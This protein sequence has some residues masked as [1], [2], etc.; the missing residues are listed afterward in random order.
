MSHSQSV[1]SKIP[2]S[3]KEAFYVFS[4]LPPELRNDIYDLSLV[5]SERVAVLNDAW[6]LGPYLPQEDSKSECQGLVNSLNFHIWSPFAVFSETAHTYFLRH[7]RFNVND[8]GAARTFAQQA[9]GLQKQGCSISIR[10]LEVIVGPDPAHARDK[11]EYL[12][13]QF[14]DPSD[15]DLG[16]GRY[17]G[18]RALRTLKPLLELPRLQEI[19]ITLLQHYR[20]IIYY[21][22]NHFNNGL[23]LISSVIAK[24]KDLVAASL[25]SSA[26]T[27]TVGGSNGSSPNP[28]FFTVT[29]QDT[30]GDADVTD[31]T[32][33]WN[34]TLDDDGSE[35]AAAEAYDVVWQD[36]LALDK[37]VRAAEHALYWYQKHHNTMGLDVDGDTDEQQQ[38]QQQQDEQEGNNPAS[39][40]ASANVSSSS[41]IPTPS[42]QPLARKAREVDELRQARQNKRDQMDA[43][44]AA[45]LDGSDL[46]VR[47]LVERL[48]SDPEWEAKAEGLAKM[49]PREWF[50]D[51]IIGR[52]RL[53]G[54]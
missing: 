1:Q 51:E 18:L 29:I 24:L 46:F 16:D 37:Q 52:R 20:E 43:L 5:A 21:S 3:W 14:G 22:N 42:E 11:C 17:P 31:M 32:H 49:K 4:R 33:L 48:A 10:S 6:G 7:N 30:P 12:E 26:S 41:A 47:P 2:S 54:A 25:P 23:L 19:R 35:L 34:G 28:S 9:A 50:Y 27:N 45:Q 38:Q 39:T 36:Y 44:P 15:F 13:G 53:Y 40:S 8:R